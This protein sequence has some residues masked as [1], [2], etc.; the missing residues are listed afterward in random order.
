MAPTLPIF[1]GH[2]KQDIQVDYDFSVQSAQT[3]ASDLGISFHESEERL[4]EAD[5]ATESGD[6]SGVCFMSYS[7]LGHWM[8]DKEMDDLGVWIRA[9]LPAG[10]AEV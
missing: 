5:L 4:I 1:W 6:K 3:L 8:N 10:D 9:L 2:G 7:D